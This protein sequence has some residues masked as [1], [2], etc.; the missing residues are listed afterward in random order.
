M[1]R[2]MPITNLEKELAAVGISIAAGCK[3]CTDYHMKAVRAA[4]AEMPAVREAVDQA[5]AVR[6]AANSIMYAYGL[7]HLGDAVAAPPARVDGHRQGVLTGLGAA[8]A[9][10]CTSTLEQHIAAA[11]DA[12]IATNE[13]VEIAKLARFIKGKGASH[14]DRR[15]ETLTKATEHEPAAACCGA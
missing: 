1:E 5:A 8:F 2:I 13:I 10:N 12:G 15:I 11:A 4:G 14:V 9:V 6:A 3:P 7:A